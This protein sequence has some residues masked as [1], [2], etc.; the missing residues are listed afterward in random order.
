MAGKISISITDEHAALL[1]EAVD[2]GSYASSSE[3]I[4]EA[5]REWRARRVVGQ[6][7]DDGLASGRSAPGTTMADIKREA[8]NRRSVS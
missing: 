8:R 1:Q 4:R 5:L 6:L 2:S 7:W 3:V